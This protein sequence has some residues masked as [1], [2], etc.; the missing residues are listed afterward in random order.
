VAV[1]AVAVQHTVH[2]SWDVWEHIARPEHIT[3]VLNAYIGITFLRL[4]LLEII[5]ILVNSAVLVSACF[6]NKYYILLN[7]CS[8]PYVDYHTLYCTNYD[9]DINMILFND[10]WPE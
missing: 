9:F 1:Y 7:E 10:I 2:L 3:Y 4:L 8:Y 6:E 5:G